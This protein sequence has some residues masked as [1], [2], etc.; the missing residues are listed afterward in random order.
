MTRFP[1][2]ARKA[3]FPALR[4]QQLRMLLFRAGLLGLDLLATEPLG[5]EKLGVGSS[6]LPGRQLQRV[7]PGNIVKGM[8]ELR[9]ILRTVETKATQN[10]KVVA[11]KHLAGVLLHSLSEECYWSPLSHPLPEFMSKEENSFITQTL[12]KP[13]LYEGDNLY[14]PK[15]N[16]EEALL[17]LLISESMQSQPKASDSIDQDY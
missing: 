6:G 12:R 3:A 2:T 11:A 4:F 7:S 14:C 8:R 17:L 9:E 10:F 16:I 1:S 13:H 15:D 5:A